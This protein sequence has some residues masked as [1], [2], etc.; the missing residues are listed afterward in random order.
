MERKSH[1]EQVYAD[2]GP[3]EVSW[4][5]KEPELSLRLIKAA[6]AGPRAAVIDVGG[7]AS[8]LTGL[9]LAQ[10]FADLTVLDI[11]GK[12]LAAARAPLGQEASKVRW[13]EADIT[14]ASLPEAAFDVWHDRAVFHFLTDPIDR[15]AYLARL[16]RALRPHGQA[17]IAV[18]SAAGPAKCSGLDVARYS[19]ET[20]S[21]ELGA[22][23][24]LM[25]SVAE[26]HVTPWGAAQ[27]FIYG[28]FR[29]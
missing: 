17:V 23:W 5:Q 24:E 1:W 4:F 7:G 28:R 12:A 9:L 8:V 13:L 10:G 26:T 20:L 19:A 22:G 14:Q 21:R 25:E 16:E 27:E 29:R 15:G 18:F 2:R 3:E 11:S 6:A